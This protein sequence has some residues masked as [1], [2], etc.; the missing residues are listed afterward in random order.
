MSLPDIH[1]TAIIH[2]GAH[3]GDGVR[4]GA[5]CVIGPEVS[6]GPEVELHSHVVIEADVTVGARTQ[7]YPFAFLGGPPQHVRCHAD[8]ARLTIGSRNIIREHCTFNTATT[9]GCT[10]TRIGHENYF[11]AG[12]HIGHDCTV[13]NRNIFANNATLGGHV[14]IGDDVFLG[15]LS[16]VHQ[17]CRVG[18]Q[19]FLGG[20]AA[21]IHDVIPFG[22]ANGNYATLAGLNL[23]GLKRRKLPREDLNAL[24]HA[25]QHLFHGPGAFRERLD[26]FATEAMPGPVQTLVDFLRAEHNRPVMMAR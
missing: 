6:L 17:H 13:G 2:D 20:C 26:G 24:R 10:E 5:Y 7:I 8:K 14:V 15:G 12:A 4:I 25:Y 21:V 19:A 1:P 3:L 18:S 16:A 9:E 22:S 11:M 23:I